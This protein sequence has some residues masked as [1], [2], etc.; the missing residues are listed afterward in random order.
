MYFLY[1]FVPGYV[2]V[3]NGQISGSRHAYKRQIEKTQP[4]PRL[5]DADAVKRYTGKSIFGLRT[6]FPLLL[7][8][9]YKILD[10][11]EKD[12]ICIARF[13]N[14][15]IVIGAVNTNSVAKEA[16]LSLN[17]IIGQWMALSDTGP[18]YYTHDIMLVSNNAAGWIS[19]TTDN[20]PAE[21]LQ[22]EGL[23]VGIAPKSCQLIRIRS[24]ARP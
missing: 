21:K 5:T 6:E 2:L 11:N 24:N 9:E 4:A 22:R 20:I 1:A 17:D 13:D 19:Q 8:G 12:V 10:T 3:F 7:W 18:A 16:V 14:G 15:E 23:H